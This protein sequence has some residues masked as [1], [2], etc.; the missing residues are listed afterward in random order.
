MRKVEV[1]PHDHQWQ[2]MF[3]LEAQE[4]T[5]VLGENLV[6]IHH[7]GSTAIPNIYAKPIIDLLGE[8]KDM[9]KV[10]RYNAQIELLGYEAMGEFGIPDRRYFRK[11]NLEGIR[12]H[13]LHLFPVG[14][15]QVNRHLAFRDYLI[16]HPQIAQ[17]YSDL[18]R[19][20]AREFPDNIEGYM[21]GKDGLIKEIDRK[22]AQQFF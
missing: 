9:D 4:I 5:K 21:D 20:L 7:M 22:A 1:I 10:D 14:S 6:A 12:T 15:E 19:Q 2:Q 13:H 3:E 18:K 11:R 17:Q 8:V 16:A